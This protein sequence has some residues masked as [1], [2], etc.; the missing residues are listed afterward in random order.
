MMHHLIVGM[1]LL[2]QHRAITLLLLQEAVGAEV[3]F[4]RHQAEVAEVVQVAEV[5]R[6]ALVHVN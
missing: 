5:A 6:L 1:M 3:D 4:L 2:L